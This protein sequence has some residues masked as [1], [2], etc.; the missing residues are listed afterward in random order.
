MISISA[1][2]IFVTG[3]VW[4]LVVGVSLVMLFGMWTAQK[5]K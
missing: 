2:V 1:N 4:G 5:R 3:F